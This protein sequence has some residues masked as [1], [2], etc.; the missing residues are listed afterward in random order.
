MLRTLVGS[1]A[2]FG[3]TNVDTSCLEVACDT[4]PS[5]DPDEFLFWDG[6][7]P[8]AAAH[9]IVSGFALPLVDPFAASRSVERLV[10]IDGEPAAM[11]LVKK[12]QPGEAVQVEGRDLTGAQVNVVSFFTDNFLA[13]QLAG[14]EGDLAVAAVRNGDQ[15]LAVER[16]D[17]LTAELVGKRTFFLGDGFTPVWLFGIADLSGDA[18]AEVA[19]LAIRNSDDR[20]LV[21]IRNGATGGLERRVFFSAGFTPVTARA[22]P[23]LDGDGNP[24]IAVLLLRLDGRYKVE[25]RNASGEAATRSTF[26]TAGFTPVDFEI[27]PDPDGDGVPE[28]ATLAVRGS[29][30]RAKVEMRNAFGAPNTR[31]RFYSSGFTPIDLV[32]VTDSDS[33]GVPEWGILQLRDMD[34]R[35]AV[36]VRNAFGPKN[37]TRSFFFDANWRPLQAFD[38][39][40]ADGNGTPEIG[41]AGMRSADERLAFELRNVR[42]ESN[43]RRRFFNQ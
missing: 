6:V 17:L 18:V 28:L 16:R 38:V 41:V 21:E 33:S 7:H 5:S 43:T 8:T 4:E 40:D 15:K 29:D 30:G 12:Q 27:G 31:S 9:R 26:F 34:N 14:V 19:Y 23:D 37:T 36:E 32:L 35:P 13:I 20:P 39:G 11:A 22:L 2:E 10:D 25:M 1:P 42:G 3:L 24:E